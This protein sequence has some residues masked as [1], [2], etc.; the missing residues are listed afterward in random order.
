MVVFDKK[1]NRKYIWDLRFTAHERA[2]TFDGDEVYSDVGVVKG[3]VLANK[4][5]ESLT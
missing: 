2:V 3:T 1:V 5:K 4:L